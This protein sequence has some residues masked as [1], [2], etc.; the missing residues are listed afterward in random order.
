MTK[1]PLLID[2]TRS[3]QRVRHGTPSGI[4]RVERAYL[5][6]AIE[7]GA[8][9][10][11]RIG[12][13]QFIVPPGNAGQLLKD[14]DRP[15]GGHLAGRLRPWRHPAVRAAESAV[16]R[17]ASGAAGQG[18]LAK[19]LAAHV[20]EGAVALN[21]GHDNLSP[22]VMEAF[23]DAGLRPVVLVHDT[24]PLDCPEFARPETPAR[25][26]VKLKAAAAAAHVIFT[27]RAAAGLAELRAREEGLTLPPHTIIP[28]GIGAP[29]PAEPSPAEPSPGVPSF[30]CLGTIEGRKNHL[31]LLAIWRRF[32]ETR[33]PETTPHLHIIGR[34][35]WEAAQ[36]FAVLDRAPMMGRTVFEH[37]SLPDAEVSRLLGQAR[38]LLFPSLAEGFGL[39]L[40]EALAAGVPV[41]ASNLAALR[42]VGGDAPE[43]LDPLDG[44]GWAEMIDAYAADPSP[45]RAAQ[46]ERMQRWAPPT[47]RSHFTALDRLLAELGSM[48]RAM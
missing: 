3:V 26:R 46:L 14:L 34:R 13:R 36:V 23:R 8:A 11:C 30:V 17:R 24:I 43:W 38:A 19:L 9:L 33:D 37:A 18:G 10:L 32:W 31:L 5:D 2:V 1:A 6:F 12:G 47:W 44:P 25:F 42:E 7:R 27:T 22:E 45:R 35:G 21:V 29:S 20:S 28:L 4:D 15:A 48:Q 41:I 39:P 16:R 40:A